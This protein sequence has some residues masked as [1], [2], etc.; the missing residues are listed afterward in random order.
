[1]NFCQIL[2]NRRKWILRQMLLALIILLLTLCFYLRNVTTFFNYKIRQEM[3]Q[4]GSSIFPSFKYKITNHICD[5]NVFLLIIVH[6]APG[7]FGHRNVIRDTWGNLGKEFPIV[8]V[9]FL[10]A[11]ADH[12]QNE[13]EKESHKNRDIVQGNFLDS[14]RN[15]TYKHLM[16]LAWAQKFCKQTKFL[17]KMDDDIY[18]DIYQFLDYIKLQFN[19]TALLNKIACYFQSNMP[20]VR[21]PVSKWYITK[22]EYKEDKFENYCS[23]WAYLTTINVAGKLHQ[24]AKITPYFWVDDVH[25]TGTLASK[26]NVSLIRLNH[27]F[28][29]ETDGLA[30]WT[31]KADDIKWNKMFAPTWGD[32]MISRHAHKKSKT[33]YIA[34]CRCCYAR[35]TTSVPKTKATTSKGV[36]KLISLTHNKWF[37]S[38]HKF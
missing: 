26:A 20:V 31:Y 14:Y 30:D 15:L 24:M 25:V 17:L 21:D 6:S 13:I 9:A 29:I 16:G 22:E 35:K 28:D 19:Q 10:L 12:L 23:G 18:M 32:L 7:H 8:K 27:L 38:K 34:K 33:C 1:M 11:A 36:A 37:K 5:E 2:L 3:L 4:K